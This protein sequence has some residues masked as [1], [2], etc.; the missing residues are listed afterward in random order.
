MAK[1]NNSKKSEKTT[2]KVLMSVVDVEQ[3]YVYDPAEDVYGGG[4]GVVSW[5]AENNLPK[6][7]I[8]CAEK[9]ATL[10]A[11]IDQSINYAMGDDI[12][13]N[14][15]AASWAEKVNRRGLSM[16]DLINRILADYFTTGNF[17]IQV[18]SLSVG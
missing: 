12:I 17:A 8:N 3:K 18:M 2:E 11:C 1:N 4:D 14:E 15:E 6:L 5:G 16:K 10:K 13:V 7:L 9:S